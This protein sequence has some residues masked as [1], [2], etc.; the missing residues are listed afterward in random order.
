MAQAQ[1]NPQTVQAP[2]EDENHI[3]AE[4]RAKLAALRAAGVAYPNDFKRTDL[5]GDLTAKYGA[6]T[7]EELEAAAPEVA[8]SGRIMLKRIMG[9]A[10]F[11]TVR[12]FTGTMQ[13][14]VQQNEV[15]PDAYAAFKTFDLGDIVAAKGVLFRTHAGDLAIRVKEIRLMTKSIRPLPDK[16][17][18]LQDTELCYRQRYV[19]LIM[20]E[21]SRNR[22]LTRSKAIAA[23]RAFML[24]HRFLEVETPMLHPIPGGANAKPFITHHN[25]LDMDMYLRIAPELYLKRLVVG[26]FERVFEINRNFRNEGVS[27]RHNPE[28]TMMEFYATYWTY[29]DQMDF[30]EEL[31]RTVAKEATGSMVLQ[32]QGHEIDLSKPFHRLTPL[33]AIKKFAPNY[34]DEELN[35]PDFIRAELKRLGGE[36]PVDAGLGALQ[37]ALFEETAEAKLIE[38]TFIIDYPVEISPLARASDADPEITERF[39]LYIAGRETANGFSDERFLSPWHPVRPTPEHFRKK[40]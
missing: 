6:M 35:N 23:I 32:Y 28:F 39:E 24:N 16:H 21:E 38:P 37:M 17:K 25:A 31:L 29:R 12:D 40:G 34:T 1:Q 2:A 11:C 9:K 36:I 33:A 26:G 15:G 30:T 14:F 18:G 5:F 13:Y 20:N 4:R 19:D 8:C 10:S 27:V 3:I 7:T 22:F